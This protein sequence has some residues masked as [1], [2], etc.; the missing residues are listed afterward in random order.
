MYPKIIYVVLLV[1]KHHG[2]EIISSIGIFVFSFFH[3]T[4]YLRELFML[5]YIPVGCFY[6]QIVS[7][8]VNMS[9][10]ICSFYFR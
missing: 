3:S 4:M 6:Y 2:N 1:F 9:Q 8:G 7:L 5:L 10:I